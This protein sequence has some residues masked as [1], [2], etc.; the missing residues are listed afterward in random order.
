VARRAGHYCLEEGK[1]TLE[2]L[3]SMQEAVAPYNGK[4]VTL[5]VRPED[6]FDTVYAGNIATEG[7]TALS[8]VEVVEPMGSEV[9]LYLN[10]GKNTLVARV[11]APIATAGSEY[12]IPKPPSNGY[13]ETNGVD[14]CATARCPP[15]GLNA[16]AR[17]LPVGGIAGADSL[18]PKRPSNSY[19]ETYGVD[20]C[21]TARKRP[22]GDHATPLAVPG[23]T[24]DGSAAFAPNPVVGSQAYTSTK[25]ANEV[26]T[27]THLPDG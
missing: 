24:D 13:T 8:T 18:S 19:T 4:V 6:I 5:G 27:A 1:F 12:L 3:P 17:P 11:V 16:T 23:G 9:L 22:S 26:A 21:A 10:T 15:D 25:G 20:E 2:L 7:R 14:V